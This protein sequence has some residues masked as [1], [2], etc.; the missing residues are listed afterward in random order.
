[1]IEHGFCKTHEYWITVFIIKQLTHTALF[2]LKQHNSTEHRNLKVNSI[3]EVFSLIQCHRLSTDFDAVEDY[4][5]TMAKS[6]KQLSAFEL[7]TLYCVINF[8]LF[9]KKKGLE[10][11]ALPRQ[12]TLGVTEE[13]SHLNKLMVQFLDVQAVKMWTY[14]NDQILRDPWDPHPSSSDGQ[15]SVGCTKPSL[16]QDWYHAYLTSMQC[17]YHLKFIILSPSP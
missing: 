2:S 13:L 6:W 9:K 10:A 8:F 3:T 15:N 4:G 14:Q 5:F 12:A 16:L 7:L 1:M 17:H 11:G